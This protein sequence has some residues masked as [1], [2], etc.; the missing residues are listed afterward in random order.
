VQFMRRMGLGAGLAVA[1]GALGVVPAKAQT[2]TTP[3]TPPFTCTGTVDDT[4]EFTLS[5][6]FLITAFTSNFDP[7]DPLLDP[8]APRLDLFD[9]LLA[10][11][12]SNE[13]GG[14]DFLLDNGFPFSADVGGTTYTAGGMDALIED[15]LLGAGDYTVDVVDLFGGSETQFG[16]DFRVHVVAFAV[17]PD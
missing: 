11:Q 3:Q 4:I 17:S 5:D 2:C 16:P 14:G 12:A 6:A 8:A 9:V 7:D 13:L 15:L 1:I 10:L